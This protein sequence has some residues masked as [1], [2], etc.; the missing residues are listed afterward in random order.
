MAIAIS[1]SMCTLFFIAGQSP[2]A[3]IVKQQTEEGAGLDAR[4]NRNFPDAV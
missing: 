2:F 3:S 1:A 4:A